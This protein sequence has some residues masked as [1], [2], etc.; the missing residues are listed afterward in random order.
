MRVELALEW[1]LVSAALSVKARLS[2]AG[3]YGSTYVDLIAPGLPLQ[4]AAHRG[5]QIRTDVGQLLGFLIAQ[6]FFY[7]FPVSESGQFIRRAKFRPDGMLSIHR[8]IRRFVRYA[9]EKKRPFTL[10]R[11]TYASLSK[12]CSTSAS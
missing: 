12:T 5:I 9:L 2:Y 11:K 8:K 3:S 1:S 4:C 6:L 10:V 7:V